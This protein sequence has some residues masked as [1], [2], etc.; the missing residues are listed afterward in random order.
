MIV[1][2]HAT[3]Q[4][5]CLCVGRDFIQR[6]TP[7]KAPAAPISTSVQC[8]GTVQSVSL[9]QRR[10]PEGVIVTHSS[11]GTHVALVPVMGTA[12]GHIEAPRVPVVAR[13]HTAPVVPAHCVEEV[14]ANEAPEHVLPHSTEVG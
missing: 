12:T 9:R 11:V 6:H 1:P 4:R 5:T 3:A 2:T 10:C 14:H 8:D 7:T 13:Q